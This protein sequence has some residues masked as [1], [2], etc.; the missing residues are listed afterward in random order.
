MRRDTV[1]GIVAPRYAPDSGGIERHV[2]MI[3]HGLLERGFTVEVITTDP[4]GHLPVTE[5][6]EGVLV[7]RFA[8]VA[9]DSV[10]YVAPALG[11]WLLRNA[12]RFTLLHA[13]SYH[14]PLAF[15]TALAARR[16]RVPLIV[17]PHYHGVGH[18]TLRKALHVPY[19][20]FGTWML[21]QARLIICV[22]QMERKLLQTHFGSSLPCEVIPNGVDV[23][24][25]LAA[26]PLHRRDEQ[27]TILVV[28]R[29]EG[30]K[31]VERLV[32]VLP[33]L[34]L[35]YQLVIIG[36]GPMRRRIVQRAEQYGVAERLHLPGRVAQ[37][38][39]ARWYRS[40]DLFVTL[41]RHEAFGMTILEAAA[42]GVPVLA[43]DIPAHREVAGYVAP[44]QVR[45]V[46]V[47]CTTNA[48]MEA[49]LLESRHL[50]T[51]DMTSW[52]LPTWQNAI[53]RT[54]QC[55]NRILGADQRAAPQ[56]A[57]T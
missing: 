17:T 23:A 47:D 36:D 25:L 10:F 3:A 9:N 5:L 31:Q 6:R 45:F 41:S 21:Q 48:L 39:L 49:V 26:Q 46:P 50:D 33:R 22:S 54:T 44:G 51:V 53:E 15:Q 57:A 16:A 7:R 27:R 11:N 14:T 1:V 29:L 35:S 20:P 42:T 52:A 38:E 24:P 8:T 4:T 56:K 40:S 30:Y 2:E 13:H 34:P 55:Y 32:E 12:A 28:S 43:S 37:E 18:T 19:G